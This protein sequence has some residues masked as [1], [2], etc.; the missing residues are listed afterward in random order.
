MTSFFMDKS[1]P[2][3]SASFQHLFF[4]HIHED[5]I[6]AV[7]T[8]SQGH[9]Y[10]PFNRWT[11]TA[12]LIYSSCCLHMIWRRMD[13]VMTRILWHQA[14]A[15]TSLFIYFSMICFLILIVLDFPSLLPPV[16]SCVG[17]NSMPFS[18]DH[19]SFPSFH[20]PLPAW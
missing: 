1:P 4:Q 9:L 7:P 16:T 20:R 15:P 10:Q 17:M 6:S 11:A 13:L 5:Q 19:P 12:V 3:H 8:Y 18:L 2:S 14:I